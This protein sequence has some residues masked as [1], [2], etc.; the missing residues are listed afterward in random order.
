MEIEAPQAA[1]S[2]FLIKNS[3]QL[4][5]V[6]LQSAFIENDDNQK[7][8]PCCPHKTLINKKIISYPLKIVTG[9]YCIQKMHAIYRINN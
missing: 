6:K 5:N 1:E 2:D 3:S 7:L 4:I 9:T 8:V